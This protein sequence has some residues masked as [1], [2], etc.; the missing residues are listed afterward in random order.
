ML[1]GRTVSNA[2]SIEQVNKLKPDNDSLIT[3]TLRARYWYAE[4]SYTAAHILVQEAEK[5]EQFRELLLSKETTEVDAFPNEPGYA[6]VEVQKWREY[7]DSVNEKLDSLHLSSLQGSTAESKARKKLRCDG[8]KRFSL[9]NSTKHMEN[10]EDVISALQDCNKLEEFLERDLKSRN[11]IGFQIGEDGTAYHMK[12]GK[13]DEVTLPLP[14]GGESRI[15]VHSHP[16]I[17]STSG[18]LTLS[19]SDMDVGDNQLVTGLIT[20]SQHMFSVEWKGVA[21][22]FSDDG[23]ESTE[24]TISCDGTTNGPARERWIAD[25]T[26]SID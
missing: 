6:P 19:D 16:S 4:A 8:H 11:E 7:S 18:S 2:L 24:F 21:I 14:S 25:P 1:N 5:D 15:I 23:Y 17:D 13:W 22:Y 26:I 12:E 3:D 10:S 9:T 20:L